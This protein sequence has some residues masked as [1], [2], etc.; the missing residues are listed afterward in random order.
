MSSWQVQ[1]AKQRFSEVLRQA[2]LGKPQFITRHGREVAVI[3][4]V[5]DYRATHHPSKTLWEH[6]DAIPCDR[7]EDYDLNELIGPRRIEE[8]RRLWFEEDGDESVSD[9]E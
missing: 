7:G 5:S 3:I 2:E 6:L 4:D 8:P 9:A 1:E